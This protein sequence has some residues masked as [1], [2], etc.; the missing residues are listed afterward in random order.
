VLDLF[1]VTLA[2]AVPAHLARV[3]PTTPTRAGRLADASVDP[4]EAR[5]SND[6][7]RDRLAVERPAEPLC[8]ACEASPPGG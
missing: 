8:Q 2:P 3:G 4:T 6:G 5:N 7:F 1:S